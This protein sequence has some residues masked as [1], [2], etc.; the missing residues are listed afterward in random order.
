MALNDSNVDETMAADWAAILEKHAVEEPE[1]PAPE[2]TAEPTETSTALEDKSAAPA[3]DESGKFV[4]A[5]K[6]KEAVAAPPAK[7]GSDKSA[8]S[9]PAEN[10][11]ESTAEAAGTLPSRDTNRAPSSW[12]PLERAIWD[13]IPPEAR[14]AIH[15]REAES[16]AGAQQLVPD[17]QLGKGMRQVIEPYRMLIEAEGGTPERAVGDL[18]KTAAIF[19][20]GTPQQKLHAVAGIANQFGID[21]RPL[22]QP[23]H[24]GQQ[25]NPQP[26]TFRDPRVDQLLANQ[27]R[28]THER[29]QRE[30][31]ELETTV[32][33]WMN[34]MGADGQPTRPYINDV[35]HEMSALIP[36]IKESNPLLTNAQALEEA[37]SRA[38]WAHPE[39]RVLL[40]QKAAADRQAELQ[41][42]NQTRVREA[43]RAA[44]VNVPRRASTPAV[45]KP[46]TMEETIAATARELGLIST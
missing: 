45:G 7:G 8:G 23:T 11:T 44:S 43:R 4:K 10:A 31:A 37:Y 19:R 2:E 36:Q 29:T 15:R 16:H 12:K 46:G 25:P 28:E 1:T 21:L 6:E 34:E 26:Q 18:L 27:Q 9:Q 41:A 30:A 13:K 24:P 22:F 20:V 5:P 33:R 40:Q 17:A 42:E 39:V 32:T 35:I 38:T 14:A 3:R